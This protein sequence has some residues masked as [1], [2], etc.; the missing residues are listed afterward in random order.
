[1]WEESRPTQINPTADCPNCLKKC[2]NTAFGGSG[3]Q[4]SGRQ[5]MDRLRGF[6]DHTVQTERD[7]DIEAKEFEQANEQ[8]MGD[9]YKIAE[10]MKKE[11]AIA[12]AEASKKK[13]EKRSD[14]FRDKP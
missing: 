4:F 9:T 10:E 14:R 11:K 12:A 7:A 5:L 13:R 1:V 3:F 8:M 6:P 2:N